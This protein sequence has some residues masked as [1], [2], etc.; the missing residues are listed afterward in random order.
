MDDIKYDL[1]DE[2]IEKIDKKI[3]IILEHSKNV[4]I[5]LVKQQAELNY[6]ILRTNLLEQEV[7]PLKEHMINSKAT[8]KV[9]GALLAGISIILG[10][11]KY[12]K[13][14]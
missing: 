11:L 3:D 8:T 4:D 6:H 13:T 7:K 9:V 2:K 10:I 1:L 5:T 14:I 12:F